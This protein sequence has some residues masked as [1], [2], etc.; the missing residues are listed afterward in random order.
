MQLEGKGKE[1]KTNTKQKQ[2]SLENRSD[3]YFHPKVKQ[4]KANEHFQITFEN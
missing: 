1:K 3:K 4:I 2:I